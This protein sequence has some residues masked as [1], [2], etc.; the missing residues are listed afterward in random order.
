M[1]FVF[2][3]GTWDKRLEYL[4]ELPKGKVL[5]WFDRSDLFRAKKILSDSM[6]L[7][8]DMPVSLLTSGTPQQIQ[9]YTK[10]LIE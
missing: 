6:C 8:G 4:K 1:P 3:E 5:G 9:D 10:R 2:W 7:M